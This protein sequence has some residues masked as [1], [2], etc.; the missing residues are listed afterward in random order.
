MD[1]AAL[2]KCKNVDFSVLMVPRSSLAGYFF[3]CDYFAI[4][5][6]SCLTNAAGKVKQSAKYYIEHKHIFHSNAKGIDLHKASVPFMQHDTPPA[7]TGPHKAALC[8]VWKHA[9]A[10][11]DAIGHQD[12]AVMDCGRRRRVLLLHKRR[13][14]AIPNF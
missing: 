10:V 4:T 11:R 12:N 9:H 14:N 5:I 7:L 1:S 13:D 3:F 2:G 6:C 8:V